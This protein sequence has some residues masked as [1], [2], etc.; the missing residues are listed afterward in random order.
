V[1]QTFKVG[2]TGHRPNR[3]HV[4]V[5]RVR[6]RL[7]TT[8]TALKRGAR[9]NSRNSPKLVA[10]SPLAEGSDRLFAEAALSLGF[11][12]HALLPMSGREYETTFGEVDQLPNYKELLSRASTVTELPGTLNDSTA[13]YEAVGQAIVDAAQL[14]IAVWDGK[15][16]AGRGG[17]PEIME[18]AL[19]IGRPIIW[20]DAARD[21]PPMLLQRPNADTVRDL[22]LATLAVRAPTLTR[23]AITA[24]AERL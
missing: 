3:M 17:T 20:I 12:V 15:P 6:Q 18:Y 24:L 7:L 5:A 11:E 4:G 19:S 14:L 1:E 9:A 21:R 8:L 16:A 2:I 23:T 13:A 10:I 22:L